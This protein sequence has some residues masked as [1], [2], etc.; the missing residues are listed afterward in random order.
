MGKSMGMLNEPLPPMSTAAISPDPETDRRNRG[1]RGTTE[2]WWVGEGVVDPA[3]VL[4]RYRRL[5]KISRN[6]GNEVLDRVPKKTLL[7]WGK[8]L[9]LVRRKAFIADGI[10]EMTLA[11]DLAVYSARPGKTPPIELYRRTAGFPA[12]GDEAVMLDAMS[13]SRFSLFVVKRRHAA[14]GLVLEDLFQR[15]EIWLMDAGLEIT[16]PEG[17]AIASRVIEPDA[18]HMTTGAAVPISPEALED[19]AS[20]F[21]FTDG[22]ASLKEGTNVKFIEAVYRAAVTWRLMEIIRFE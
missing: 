12:G 21:P 2:E 5:R 18:F 9:G 8:R 4:A 1:G 13:R 3:D 22:D 6:H 20:N 16:A 7:D 14:A 17:L 19:V 15:R 11:F 10:E